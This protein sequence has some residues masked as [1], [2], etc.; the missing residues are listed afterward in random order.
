MIEI[1]QIFLGML[2]LF[3]GLVSLA[4]GGFTMYFGAGKSRVIGILL[5]VLGLVVFVLLYWLV[6]KDEIIGGDVVTGSFIA[7]LAAAIGAVVAV[8]I[9]IVPMMFGAK[10]TIDEIESLADIETD[11]R[12]KE[13][14]GTERA[15]E[16]VE[17]A[18]VMPE[19]K[20]DA[21]Q[22][23]GEEK[24]EKDSE[25][26][27]PDPGVCIY[28]GSTEDIQKGHLI[29]PSKGGKMEV[30]ACATCNQSKGD[31]ALMEWLRWV[32]ENRP[33]RWESIVAHNKFKRSELAQK[34][35]KIRDEPGKTPEEKPEKEPSTEPSKTAHPEDEKLGDLGASFRQL[36]EKAVG[37]GGPEAAGTEEPE[38]PKESEDKPTGEG[39]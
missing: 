34:V 28:C 19:A 13:E 30:S 18:A 23:T 20:E 37:I 8:G 7:V 38:K 4:M 25:E 32:K 12:L 11:S 29:A 1:R 14:A 15:E 35:H 33:E 9:V 16:K 26:A 39:A 21:P 22:V 17:P 24:P 5:L 6:V 31:K 2:L 36:V 3:F 10:E 27:E